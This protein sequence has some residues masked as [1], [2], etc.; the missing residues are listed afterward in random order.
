MNILDIVEEPMSPHRKL[1]TLQRR[2]DYLD[3]QLDIAVPRCP[4]TQMIEAEACALQ[5]AISVLAP[6]VEHGCL[7][8]PP[9]VDHARADIEGV[10]FH[11]PTATR[12][13]G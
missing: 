4:R 8:H 12:Q 3:A 10:H 1:R 5:W 9:T 7:I 6:V 11:P 13:R 2:L